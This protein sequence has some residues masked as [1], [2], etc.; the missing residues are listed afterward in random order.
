M[1]V[2]RLVPRAKTI[3]ARAHERRQI[4]TTIK[5]AREPGLK[6]VISIRAA[7]REAS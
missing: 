6:V 7:T 4:E 2:I 1:T 5:L 3:K